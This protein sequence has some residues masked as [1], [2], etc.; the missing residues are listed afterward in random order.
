MKATKLASD[1]KGFLRISITK[2]E[3][4]AT[5]IERHK[6]VNLR[7][8][9]DVMSHWKE[10]AKTLICS[11]MHYAKKLLSTIKRYY[12]SFV[13]EIEHGVGRVSLLHFLLFF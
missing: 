2:F 13:S 12:C 7:G 5:Q 6:G 9:D 1:A 10:C 4:V 11:K 3:E 8:V